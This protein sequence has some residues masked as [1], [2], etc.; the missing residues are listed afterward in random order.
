VVGADTTPRLLGNIHSGWRPGAFRKHM[1]GGLRVYV[2]GRAR[3]RGKCPRSKT[4][5]NSAALGKTKGGG[6]KR[7]QKKGAAGEG[8]HQPEKQ[9]FARKRPLIEGKNARERKTSCFKHVTDEIRLN[10]DQVRGVSSPRDQSRTRGT[11]VWRGKTVGGDQREGVSGR[12]RG[13]KGNA[14]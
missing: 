12:C 7:G 1:P 5:K 14:G 6:E 9:G 4:V 13:C 3:S 10:S 8:D 11:G 2:W